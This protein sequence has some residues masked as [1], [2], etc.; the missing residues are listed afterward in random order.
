MPWQWAAGWCSAAR[1]RRSAIERDGDG[2]AAAGRLRRP[3]LLNAHQELRA[4]GG[5]GGALSR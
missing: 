3:G 4:G 5:D 1:G 2:G